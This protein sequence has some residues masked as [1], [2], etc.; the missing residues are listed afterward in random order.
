MPAFKEHAKLVDPS[1]L[2]VGRL[3]LVTYLQDEY[4][5]FTGVLLKADVDHFLIRVIYHRDFVKGEVKYCALGDY[6]IFDLD[7]VMEE[8]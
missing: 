3:Y 8:V 1:N 6:Q 5:P 2:V 4:P 7:D